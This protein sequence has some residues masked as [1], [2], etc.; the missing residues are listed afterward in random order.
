[1]KKKSSP[2]PI[3][4]AASLAVVFIVNFTFLYLAVKTEDGLTDKNYYEKGLFYN[5]SLQDEKS[6]GWKIEVS[7]V[8]IPEVESSNGIMVNIR[9]TAG[10]PVGGALVKIVLKRPASDR[11]DRVFELVPA[12]SA[13]NGSISM[14]VPGWWDIEVKA[15][16]DGKEMEK[17]FRIK[18]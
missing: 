9:D 11:F 8:N 2:W 6:L 18:V 1:M 16:K 14:P 7:F 15:K 17:T 5:S 3:A 13:Y 12:G 10:A 4:I